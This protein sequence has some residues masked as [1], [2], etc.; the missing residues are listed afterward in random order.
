MT[1]IAFIFIIFSIYLIPVFFDRLAS[2]IEPA[3]VLNRIA[4]D[5][6]LTIKARLKQTASSKLSKKPP[7][8]K[9][10][11]NKIC[12][13]KSGY[14][15]LINK[16]ALVKICQE[17]DLVGSVPIKVGHFLMTGNPLFFYKSKKK[18]DQDCLKSILACFTV[19]P[20]R[21]GADDLELKIEEILGILLHSLSPSTIDLG[22]AAE[23]LNHL[24]NICN[25]LIDVPLS[26][27]CYMDDHNKV[28]LHTEES[29]FKTL[30]HLTFDSVRQNAVDQPSIIL[31]T[32]KV[33]QKATYDCK[34]K[35]RRKEIQSIATQFI[36]ELHHQPST[37]DMAVLKKEL[38]ALHRKTNF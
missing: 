19:S 9:K 36:K 1:V 15:T 33:F 14:L 30:M 2:S 29:D 28:R 27:I 26:P 38:Q 20:S 13:A 21:L 24:G 3:Y 23:A 5:I 10:Y 12:A 17:F 35:N 32:L 11:P 18:L 4:K 8:L 6:H 22:T 25:E 37:S 31:Q 34:N 16:D 7:R